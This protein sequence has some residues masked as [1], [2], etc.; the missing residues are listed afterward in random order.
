[1]GIA[2]LVGMV[3]IILACFCGICKKKTTANVTPEL[4]VHY[5]A[6]QVPGPAMYVAGPSQP[7]SGELPPAY[8]AAGNTKTSKP[9]QP[10]GPEK[11]GL[12]T[13]FVEPDGDIPLPSALN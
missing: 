7:A 9:T 10:P 3:S 1:M 12:G 6:G 4:H 5:H 11:P 2:V 8:T 13:N